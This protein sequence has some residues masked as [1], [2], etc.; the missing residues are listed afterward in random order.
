MCLDLCGDHTINILPGVPLESKIYIFIYIIKVKTHKKKKKIKL[1]STIKVQFVSCLLNYFLIFVPNIRQYVNIHLNDLLSTKA[2][3]NLRL[4]NLEII[5]SILS[6]FIEPNK[7]LL[8]RLWGLF[9]QHGSLI[10]FSF[11]FCNHN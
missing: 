4:M 1:D 2:K 5:L 8:I 7:I 9:T 3:K 11:V 6:Q 10:F